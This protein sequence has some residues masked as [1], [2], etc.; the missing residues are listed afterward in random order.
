MTKRSAS[1][2]YKA[3]LQKARADKLE[4][5]ARLIGAGI[6]EPKTK[7]RNKYNRVK[8]IYGGITYDSMGEAEYANACANQS[9]PML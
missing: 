2:A 9:R 5:R 8:T 6:V 3:I 7:R 4:Q 1:S